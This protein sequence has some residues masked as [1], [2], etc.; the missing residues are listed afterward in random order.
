MQNS[1]AKSLAGFGLHSKNES[2]LA[3]VSGGVD[4]MVLLSLFYEGGFRLAVAHLNYQLRGRE[5]DLDEELVRNWCAMRNVPFHSKRVN[6]FEL[7]EESNSSVQMVARNERYSFFEELMD[8]KGYSVTAL[9]HHADDRV[10]SLLINVL[11]GTGLRGLQG[12]PSRR[13]RFI[14]PLIEFRNLEIRQYAQRKGILFREDASNAKTD[15]QRNWVRHRLLPMLET[16]HPNSVS[17]MIVFCQRVERELPNYEALI[18]NELSEFD[19]SSALK[20][21]KLRGSKVPFTLLKEALEPIGFSSDQV[22]EVLGMLDSES[23]SSVSSRT[24]RVLRDRESLLIEPL[25]RQENEPRLRFELIPRATISSLKTESN[26]ALLNGDRITSSD[27]KLRKWQEGDRFK[28]LGMKGWKKISDFF[29]DEKLSISEKD[30]TWLLI[31]QDEVVWVVGM[32]LDNRF[33][34]TTDTQKVLKISVFY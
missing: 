11:R 28:P 1:F 15:Y 32:R 16:F 10:E 30:K 4:S 13:G 24:H 7:A 21:D 26:I 2:Y 29:I 12:M 8:S 22:F 19:S 23:G 14:R 25:F 27:L 3:A 31:Y 18:Q 20:L 6:T 34:V 33:K 5:S 9:A 17:A